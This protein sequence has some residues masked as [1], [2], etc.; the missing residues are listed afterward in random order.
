MSICQDCVHLLEGDRSI[1]QDLPGLVESC[2][3]CFFCRYLC[4]FYRIPIPAISNGSEW[5]TMEQTKN[6]DNRDINP[7]PPDFKW[8]R[9]VKFWVNLDRKGGLRRIRADLVPQG[10]FRSAP[11]PRSASLPLGLAGADYD[12]GQHALGVYL[13]SIGM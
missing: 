11:E 4:D 2:K 13:S 3:D 12:K 1:T 6:Y 9:K 7:Q 8:E 10:P 5:P